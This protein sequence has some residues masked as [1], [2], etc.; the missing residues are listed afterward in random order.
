MVLRILE[1]PNYITI[2]GNLDRG[3][4]RAYLPW[5]WPGAE[6]SEARAEGSGKEDPRT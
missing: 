6:D 4:R 1:A 2:L 3:G 5:F